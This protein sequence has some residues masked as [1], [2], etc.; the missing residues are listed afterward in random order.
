M[1][2]RTFF[3][4]YITEPTISPSITTPLKIRKEPCLV[5]M[6]VV[7]WAA[8]CLTSSSE[9]SDKSTLNLWLRSPRVSVLSRVLLLTIYCFLS[10]GFL[11][12]GKTIIFVRLGMVRT[13]SFIPHNWVSSAMG[14]L[15]SLLLW[16][17]ALVYSS[18]S[19]TKKRCLLSIKSNSFSTNSLCSVL[20]VD[21]LSI[22]S[23]SI[24]LALCLLAFFSY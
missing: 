7:F 1:F 24:Y 5:N 9:N 21:S 18:F 14:S 22:F 13:R 17:L 6:K 10:N 20:I 12:S 3:C 16:L 11:G 15:L 4:L 8:Y 2:F 19:G 23:K